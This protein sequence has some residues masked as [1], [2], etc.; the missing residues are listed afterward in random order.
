MI[1]LTLIERFQR[2]VSPQ[3]ACDK[4]AGIDLLKQLESLP[5]KETREFGFALVETAM[6]LQVMMEHEKKL[7][8]LDES[9]EAMIR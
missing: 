1:S 8:N 2:F 3:K 7:R 5:V 4:E 9:I 6:I